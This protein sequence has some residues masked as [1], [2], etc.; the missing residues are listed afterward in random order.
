LTGE[1][2]HRELP[3]SFDSVQSIVDDGDDGAILHYKSKEGGWKLARAMFGQSD[4]IQLCSCPKNAKVSTTV[5][6]A[7]WVLKKQGKGSHW[8][9]QYLNGARSI[10]DSVDIKYPVG[11]FLGGALP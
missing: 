8:G 5:G 9:L 1:N 7:I 3:F 11:S 6:G 10:E 4:V 2:L